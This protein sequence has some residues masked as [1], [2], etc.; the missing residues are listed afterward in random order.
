MLHINR[1]I[2]KLLTLLLLFR[3]FKRLLVFFEYCK[4]CKDKVRREGY[5]NEQ[6]QQFMDDNQIMDKV[7][8]KVE[9]TQNSGQDFYY[10]GKK[11]VNK[12]DLENAYKYAYKKMCETKGFKFTRFGKELNEYDCSHTE[13]TCKRDT[14]LH[15]NYSAETT[16]KIDKSDCKEAMDDEG[17]PLMNEDGTPMITCM[18]VE[19]SFDVNGKKYTGKITKELLKNITKMMMKGDSIYVQYEPDKPES[20]RLKSELNAFKQT[21]NTMEHLEWRPKDKQCV[22]AYKPLVDFCNENGLT[23]D[24]NIGKCSV[25]RKYCECRGLEW[26]SGTV[27]CRYRPGQKETSYMFGK[28]MTQGIALPPYCMSDGHLAAMGPI[29]MAYAAAR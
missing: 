11:V 6:I 22:L 23:Y 19:Y 17:K 10:K 18:N 25:N 29:G 2:F 14:K 4:L 12:T 26:R 15:D 7:D 21:D 3:Y 16:A 20:N 1:R 9:E 13:Q 28:T 27:D 5:E 8:A 24:K